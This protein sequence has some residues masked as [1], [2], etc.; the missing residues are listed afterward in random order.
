LLTYRIDVH[1]VATVVVATALPACV[2]AL[3]EPAGRRRPRRFREHL[4]AESRELIKIGNE[5]H[6]RHFE[7][8]QAEL[9]AL[10]ENTVDYL[11]TK[12]LALVAYLLRQTGR[13]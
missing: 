7:H 3:W 5:F 11:F 6:I 9:P 2:A 13:L 1:P 12:L 8:D 10:V 4:L